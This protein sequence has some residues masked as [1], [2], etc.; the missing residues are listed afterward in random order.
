[1]GIWDTLDY[2][3]D[4]AP[5]NL[6]NDWLFEFGNNSLSNTGYISVSNNNTRVTL[7]KS[8][9]YRIR[10][11][12]VLFGISIVSIY[13]ILIWK[14]GT[15]EIYL[16]RYETLGS[17]PTF[18]YIDSTAFVYSDGTDF[19]EINAYSNGDNFITSTMYLYS[20]LTI[21]YVAV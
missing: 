15:N 6:Q 18:Y 19:I 14:D 13:N 3:L 16:D 10:L 4:Y 7:L 1:M 5:H 9:W 20:Q 2:N 12:V 17:A 8:G 21:E 11:S